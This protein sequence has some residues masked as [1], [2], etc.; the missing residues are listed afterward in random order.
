MVLK[1][2]GKLFKVNVHAVEERQEVHK[3]GL[4]LVSEMHR[5]P[6]CTVVKVRHILS[7]GE[8]QIRYGQV[9][10]TGQ[11]WKLAVKRLGCAE[12]DL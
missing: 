5:L 3:V 12:L 4:K 9:L 2:L 11:S 6:L 10:L 7:L 8:K 1:A